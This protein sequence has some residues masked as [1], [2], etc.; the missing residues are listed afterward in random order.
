MGN[1]S[2]I[3]GVSDPNQNPESKRVNI[4]EI[5]N[6]VKVTNGNKENKNPTSTAPPANKRASK[7]GKTDQISDQKKQK[8]DENPEIENQ[9]QDPPINFNLPE[10]NCSF[11]HTN[12]LILSTIGKQIY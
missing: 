2:T 12:K 7:S 11:P 1:C 5:E 8:Y 6:I 4:D 10:D 3:C 9:N